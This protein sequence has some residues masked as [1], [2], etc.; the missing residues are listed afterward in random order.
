MDIIVLLIELLTPDP[1]PD[2]TIDQ[3]TAAILE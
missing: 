3:S 2:E 1:K